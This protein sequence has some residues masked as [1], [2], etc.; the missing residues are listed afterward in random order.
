RNV[1]GLEQA[2]TYRTGHGM[3]RGQPALGTT[4]QATPVQVGNQLVLCTP[5]NIIVSVHVDTGKEYWRFDPQ[6]ERSAPI[7]FVCRGVAYAGAPGDRPCAQRILSATL[8]NRLLALDARTG[9]P[10]P[11]FGRAGFVNLLDGFDRPL[12]GYHTVTSPPTIVNGVAVVGSFVL[13]GQST[14]EPSGVVRGYDVE[15]G[16]LLWAWDAIGPRALLPGQAFTPNTPNSWSI[17]SADPKLNLVYLPMGGGTPDFYAGPRTAERDRYGSSVTAVDARTGNVRWS[18][19]T[20]HHDIWDYDVPS[21]PVLF[22]FPAGRAKTPALAVPTKRGEIF[23]LDR[24]TGRPL[25]P[26]EERRVP[27]GGAPG[28]PLSPTQPFVSGFPSF[29]PPPL[30]EASMW[31]LTPFDQLWCRVAYRHARYEGPFTPP[32]VQGSLV[33][34][35]SFGGFNWGSMSVDPERGLLIGNFNALPYIVKLIPRKDADAKRI[36]PSG[37]IPGERVK[38]E[39]GRVSFAQAGLPFAA[40]MGAFLSPLGIPCSQPP[41]GQIGAI[42]LKQRAIRWVRP[43]GTTRDTAPLGISLPLGPPNIG[44]SITTRGGVTFVGAATDNYIRAFDSGTGNELWRSRLP[45]GG[46]ATPMTFVSPG[47]G[48]QYVVIRRRA[49]QPRLHAGGS[50][51]CLRAAVAQRA[52]VQK[53]SHTRIMREKT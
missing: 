1:A 39:N 15:N 26:V 44:G 19:Q 23:I 29:A 27:G 11:G 51:H 33:H 45:A 25:V 13:D 43:L 47:T 42:D 10:C 38:F 17:A 24:R 41:W 49:R 20:V 16:K 7:S 12:P 36:L 35:G 46:Q 40:S 48:R 14:Q 4:F 21:Q 18:F 8:D 37:S 52:G 32:S 28:E 2:W 9:R 31:G 22:D 6:I 3:F 53:P 5:F 50:S 34:T 30:R